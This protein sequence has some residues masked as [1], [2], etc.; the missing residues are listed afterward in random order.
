MAI[1]LVAMQRNAE[2]HY[3]I[4]S[5]VNDGYHYM[6]QKQPLNLD[7]LEH[8][9]LQNCPAFQE[10]CCQPGALVAGEYTERNGLV[11]HRPDSGT[12]LQKRLIH[13]DNNLRRSSK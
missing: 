5:V 12:E 9:R 3:D 7:P 13:D 2:K 1:G 8:Y 11:V 10:Y 6:S 4:L